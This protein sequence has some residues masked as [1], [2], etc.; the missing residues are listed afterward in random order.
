MTEAAC[1]VAGDPGFALIGPNRPALE[2]TLAFRPTLRQRLSRWHPGL[3]GYLAAIA[4]ASALFAACL[5]WITGQTAP[6]LALTGSFVA[7]EAGMAVVHLVVSRTVRPQRLPAMALKQG[8]PPDCR[9]L[10]AVPVLLTGAEDLAEMLQRLEVHHLSS[11]GGAVHYALLSDGPDADSETTVTDLAL[12][13]A[14][15]TGIAA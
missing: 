10:V 4:A 3:A 13:T 7:I 2:R 15:Q 14:A 8:V 6:A 12:I 1:T 11:I 9:T 5:L